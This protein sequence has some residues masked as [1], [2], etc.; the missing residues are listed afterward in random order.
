MLPGAG[1]VISE[2]VAS[3]HL[4]RDRPRRAPTR[5]GPRSR[6]LRHTTCGL[7]GALDGGRRAHRRRAGRRHR[8]H[9]HG[10]P[11]ARG[12]GQAL[13]LRADARPRSR[14]GP[15]RGGGRRGRACPSRSRCGWAG[16]MAA[17]NAPELARRAEAAGVQLHHRACAHALP[18]LQGR[19]RL[20]L[21]APREG[22]RAH[23][24][25][26]Q[27]RHRRSAERRGRARGLR[28]RCCHGGARRLRRA[29]D[30]GAHR[31]LPG[32]RTRYRLAAARRAARHRRRACRGHAGSPRRAITACAMRASTSAGISQSSGR[33]G[34]WSR[35]GAAGCARSEDAAEVL[36]GLG[37]STTPPR[38]CAA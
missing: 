31:H 36:A 32:D 16:T 29:V 9:Q 21:R 34:R 30:A 33:P 11:G 10:L 27:R 1:L 15:D 12:D 19:S 17:C 24:C 13:R 26:R 8:R 25:R 38:S 37:A 22:G 28:C 23:P 6:A 20:G 5:A 3:E 14:R 2:M 18:V 35:P 7:R 4:V